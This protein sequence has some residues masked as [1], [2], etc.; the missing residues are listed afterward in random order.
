MLIRLP[1][2]VEQKKIIDILNTFEKEIIEL[3]KKLEIIKEQKRFLLNNL[4]TGAIRT[5]E[6]LLTKVK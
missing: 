3:E 2:L 1:P 4:I 5:P 6:N